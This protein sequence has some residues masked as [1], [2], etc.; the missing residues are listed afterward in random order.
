MAGKIAWYLKDE[1]LNRDPYKWQRAEIARLRDSLTTA[2]REDWDGFKESMEF[3]DGE[4]V[5]ELS[6]LQN[7]IAV[8]NS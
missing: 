2:Q 1:P 5:I 3:F 6:Y 8:R 4:V 7:F